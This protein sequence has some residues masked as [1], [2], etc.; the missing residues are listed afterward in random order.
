MTDPFRPGI[1]CRNY[2]DSAVLSGSDDVWGNGVGTDLET[3]CVDALF[4]AQKEWSMLSAW[5][6]R[7]GINGC[8]GGFPIYV[9]LNEVNA[10]WDG[11][12]SW[13]ATTPPGNG[14]PPST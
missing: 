6:G 10:Y 7:N 9:G 5:L 12:R 1:S 3:G 8:G 14:S 13:W 2:N 4:D 11:T